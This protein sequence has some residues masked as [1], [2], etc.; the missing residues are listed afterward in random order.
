MKKSG[1][2]RCESCGVRALY[3]HDEDV[4]CSA[5]TVQQ[6]GGTVGFELLL[7]WC[8]SIQ[9]LRVARLLTFQAHGSNFTRF[10]INNACLESGSW[11]VSVYTRGMVHRRI[12]AVALRSPRQRMCLRYR[13]TSLVGPFTTEPSLS[14]INILLRFNGPRFP[15]CRPSGRRRRLRATEICWTCRDHSC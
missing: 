8:R 10:F 2:V 11:L 7:L 14:R 12:H 9:P 5:P 3:V 15:S 13:E 1:S 6:G 4:A